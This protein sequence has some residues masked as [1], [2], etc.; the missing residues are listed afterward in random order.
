[1]VNTQVITYKLNRILTINQQK[2]DNNIRLDTMDSRWY[3]LVHETSV[4][5]VIDHSLNLDES[6]YTL[7]RHNYGVL[8]STSICQH[9]DNLMVSMYITVDKYIQITTHPTN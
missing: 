3:H 2:N 8:F 5:E 1:M 6:V 7:H 4:F 9:W